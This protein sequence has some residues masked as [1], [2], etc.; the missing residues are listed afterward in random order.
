MSPQPILNLKTTCF[1][2]FLF[3]FQSSDSKKTTNQTTNKSLKTPPKCET[4]KSWFTF[5]RK[6]L[7]CTNAPVK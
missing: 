1:I 5:K 2:V 7:I 4:L 3:Q 6:Q